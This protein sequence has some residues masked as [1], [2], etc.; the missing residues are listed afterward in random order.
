M[1]ENKNKSFSI[2]RYALQSFKHYGGKSIIFMISLALTL[3]LALLNIMSSLQSTFNTDMY[4]I[5][6][7][8]GLTTGDKVV[9]IVIIVF[10]MLV[11]ALIIFNAFNIIIAKRTRHF[12]LLTLIG[13]SKKQIGKCVYIEALLNMAVALPI[14]L[15]LGT[16]ASWLFMPI[17]ETSFARDFLVFHVEP[18]SYILSAAMVIAMV[19]V[20]AGL[21]AIRAARITP[22]EAAKFMP[23]SVNIRKKFKEKKNISL[24]VLAR[25]NLFR[26]KGAKGMVASLSI[27]GVL[28]ISLAFILLSSYTSLENLVRENIPMDITVSAGIKL[29]NYGTML[30]SSEKPLFP[31]EVVERIK[32]IDGIEEIH[33]LYQQDYFE[34]Y[35]EMGY[36]VHMIIGVDDELLIKI[37]QDHFSNDEAESIFNI[38]KNDIPDD[39]VA[40]GNFAQ[41]MVNPLMVNPLKVKLYDRFANTV[42]TTF[43]VIADPINFS[44]YIIS[45]G[46]NILLMPLSSFEAKNF[47]M[48]CASIIFNIDDSKYDSI[49]ASLSEICEEEGNIHFESYVEKRREYESQM[50]SI[51]VMV[52]TGL[53]IVFAVSVLNL[54]S[55]TF[56]GIEQHKK[57]LGVLSALGLA[58]KELK[59][60]LKWEGI[61]VSIYSSLISVAGGFGAGW[62]FFW[63][64]D[65][66]MY[67]NNYIEL[68]FPVVPI[69]IF[70]LVYIFVPYIIASVAVRKLMKN[71]AVELIGQEI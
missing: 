66:K 26:K 52:M 44:K 34:L 33:V 62:L 65:S 39:Y 23:G 4:G 59:K 16:A 69:V 9:F 61:W 3:V 13:A 12:G 24:S 35:D 14:G 37:L 67:G 58:R 36:N 7:D 68:Y 42:E 15:I 6:R 45:W 18:L 32:N 2:T 48:K 30:Y 21:P 55:T 1:A 5:V 19:C 29:G 27:V 70:C 41:E 47:T 38:L 25:I 31:E 10:F 57:E 20:S 11:G 60:M 40:I 71:T 50:M 49:A 8:E 46:G 51:I 17:V 54:I 43:S 63:W 56:I 22:I 28:F 64:I 53:G